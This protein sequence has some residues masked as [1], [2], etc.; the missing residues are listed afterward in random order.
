MKTK[1]ILYLD[2]DLT[3][4]LL[5]KLEL[6]KIE[7]LELTHWA[8]SDSIKEILQDEEFDLIVSNTHIIP[9]EEIIRNLR[10]GVF[11]VLNK[12]TPAIAYT[13]AYFYNEKEK[14]LEAGFNDYILMPS[15]SVLI[16]EKIEK[17]LK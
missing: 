11:G 15:P 8:T 14:C 16:K 5:L 2:A 6:R 12:E 9:G 7:N 10:Q 3:N 1:K 17:L 13:A 4:F